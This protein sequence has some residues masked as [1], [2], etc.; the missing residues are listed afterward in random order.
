MLAVLAQPLETTRADR[1]LSRCF[2]AAAARGDQP[3]SLASLPQ[4]R[5]ETS[6]VSARPAQPHAYPT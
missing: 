6:S 2:Y 1:V 4:P 5:R 3:A